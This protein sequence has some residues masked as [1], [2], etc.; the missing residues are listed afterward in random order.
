[1]AGVVNNVFRN[2]LVED[3]LEDALSKMLHEVDP[4]FLSPKYL[5]KL[6]KMRMDAKILLYIG[7]NIM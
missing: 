7:C 2:T 5:E 4:R 1:M 3:N 6:E